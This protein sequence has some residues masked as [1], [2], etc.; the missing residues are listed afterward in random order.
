MM[1][2]AGRE[3][4]NIHR[5]AL[6][7]LVRDILDKPPV[8]TT[9]LASPPK[10]KTLARTF[11]PWETID[12]GQHFLLAKSYKSAA[13]S[14]NIANQ[15]YAPKQFASYGRSTSGQFRITRVK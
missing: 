14:I 9:T 3:R 10:A 6:I 15:R 7:L 8:E 11:Y 2:R 1:K 13:P 12:K 5:E 4:K